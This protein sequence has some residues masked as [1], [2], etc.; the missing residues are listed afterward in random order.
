M[1]ITPFQA[2]L[3]AEI[4]GVDLEAGL[5][6]RD[7]EA[8][9]AAWLDRQVIVIRDQTI[10]KEAQLAF[11]RRFGELEE[12]RT[13]KDSPDEKQ[14]VLYVSN[15]VVDGSKGALPDGEMFF[16]SDQCYYESPCQATLLNALEIPPAGG[17][18]L[19]ANAQRAYQRLP[20]DLKRA[21][22][23]KRIVNVYDYEA[24]PTRRSTTFNA[25]APHFV[26]PIVVRHP[27]N[28]RPTLFVNRQMTHHIVD[29][30]LEESEQ[31][32]QALFDQL[33]AP[34]NI[35]EHV[36]RPHD[37]LMWDNRAV[38]HARRDFDPNQARILR[39][40]TVRGARPVAH[41]AGHAA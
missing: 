33:E 32:L 23:G 9:R 14:Y 34:D 39:R 25:G 5:S 17:E 30:D 4:T 31:I 38:L 22:D 29:M 18:T 1:K 8:I 41:E 6:D 24:D 21:I 28:G 15:R 2:P 13:K 36:W 26:H 12:V 35:Y 20:D 19:F 37:L 16:H 3:G 11:A 40:I 10:S 27:E 7:F